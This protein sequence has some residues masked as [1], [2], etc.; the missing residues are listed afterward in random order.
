MIPHRGLLIAWCIAVFFT[1]LFLYTRHNTFPAEFHADEPP[2]ATQVIERRPTYRQ[3]LL[4]ITATEFVSRVLNEPKSIRQIVFTGR[5]I[6]AVFA[7]GAI[8]FISL[9]G[10]VAFG[11]SMPAAIAAGIAA[12]SCPQ[13]LLLAHYMKEDTALVFA[14]AAFLVAAWYDERESSRRSAAV[15]GIAAGLLASAKYIGLLAI[16]IAYWLNATSRQPR[17]PGSRRTFT[18]ALIASWCAINYLVVVNPL[19][20]FSNLGTEAAHPIAGHHGL[21]N[22]ILVS[23]PVWP[24]LVAQANPVVLIV[25]L[26]YVVFSLT[27][28]RRLHRAVTLFV[29]GPAVYLLLLSLSRFV[30]DRHLLQVTVAAYT[31]TGFA[32][33]EVAALFKRAGLRWLA[34]GV[35]SAILVATSVVPARAIYHELKGETRLQLR[36]W[37]RSNLPS[38]AIIAQDRPAHLNIADPEFL[39]NYGPLPQQIL[40][41]RDLFVTDLGSVADLR[42]KGVTHIVTCDEAY[43]RIFSEHVISAPE[44]DEYHMRRIRYDEIFSSGKLLFEAK[45]ERPI[46]GSTSPVVRV[47]AIT[48]S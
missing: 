12:L 27:R 37:I 39:A 30:L 46:G 18:I 6:S 5:T 48:D 17:K 21:A 2:K 28:W 1:G 20:F 32:I 11:G 16:P 8:V 33:V 29:L 24:L 47:Y 13:L 25:A 36:A 10:Y 43:A 9:F 19:R 35:L 14:G 45:P 40:T 44:R 34:T 7:A 4:L 38:S 41:P 23:S 3:P 42:N 22:P 31:M 15:F 26:G